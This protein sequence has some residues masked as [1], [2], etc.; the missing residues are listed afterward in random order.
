MLSNVM[1][2]S[3]YRDNHMHLY[4]KISIFHKLKKEHQI[5]IIQPLNVISGFRIQEAEK[6]PKTVS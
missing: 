2:N 5:P 3:K 6:L 4:P 1:A